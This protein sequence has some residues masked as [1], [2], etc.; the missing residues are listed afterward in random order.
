MY[1]RVPVAELSPALQDL[2]CN[3]VW[4]AFVL[5]S[6][7]LEIQ[8]ASSFNSF[9]SSYLY[10]GI[11]GWLCLWN[12]N[13]QDKGW[14]TLLEIVTAVKEHFCLSCNCWRNGR[15]DCLMVSALTSWSNVL[16]SSPG[17]LYCVVGQETLLSQCLPPSSCINEYRRT[18]CWEGGREGGWPCNRR[19]KSRNTP[20]CFMLQKPG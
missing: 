1:L 14:V 17:T 13:E 10:C 3:G 12:Q 9:P 8:E 2:V 4:V 18:K 16:G 11:S 15:H 5:I 7:V 19:R 20:S 6:Q